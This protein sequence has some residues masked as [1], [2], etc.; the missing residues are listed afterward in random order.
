MNLEELKNEIEKNQRKIEL[1][2]QSITNGKSTQAE[3][4]IWVGCK[5]FIEG[6]KATVETVDKTIVFDD[7]NGN[8]C[9]HAKDWMELKQSLSKTQ[10]TS[11]VVS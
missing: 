5:C 7:I 11:K 4:R 6:V 2:N 10:A 8:N 3:R 1:L 9:T